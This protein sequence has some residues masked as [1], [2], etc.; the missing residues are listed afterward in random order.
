MADKNRKKKDN[1][2][3][4]V[5]E[6]KIRQDE[7]KLPEPGADFV[8]VAKDLA[9]TKPMYEEIL[10]AASDLLDSGKLKDLPPDDTAAVYSIYYEAVAGF[11]RSG[12]LCSR[13]TSSDGLPEIRIVSGNRTFSCKEDILVRIFGNHAAEEIIKPYED[14][15]NPYISFNPYTPLPEKDA[16]ELAELEKQ[17]SLQ[18]KQLRNEHKKQLSALRKSHE[19]ELKKRA[20]KEKEKDVEMDALKHEAKV[21]RQEKE[22]LLMKIEEL[23]GNAEKLGEELDKSRAEALINNEKADRPVEMPLE[24]N[25]PIGDNPEKLHETEEKLEAAEAKLREA[26]DRI[27]Q[28]EEKNTDLSR[29]AEKERAT[30]DENASEFKK[31][32][33]R[34]KKEIDEHNKYVYD[35]NYDHYYSDEL[36]QILD[37]IDFTR[38]DI[39]I[40]AGA[41]AMCVG[42]IIIS[43]LFII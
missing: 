23:T 18:M 37:S 38:T 3:E 14:L 22:E 33:A 30:Y 20:G 27:A 9:Y 35:P 21:L 24:L 32:I 29:M 36:P 16:E 11:L 25:I 15:F 43:L 40:R 12:T 17:E 19:A 6:P 28:L 7:P 5:K 4:Q 39:G 10:S 13:V 8:P 31:E 2:Q 34:Q 26:E 41:V 1:K 42:G